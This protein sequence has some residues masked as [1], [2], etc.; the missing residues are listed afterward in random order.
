MKRE[1]LICT[2]ESL[3]HQA[4]FTYF[5]NDQGGDVYL[6]IHLKPRN[7][8][9]RIINAV[10]YVFGHRSVYGDFDEMVINPEDVDKLERIVEYLKK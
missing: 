1:T 3:E 9:R 10:R 4:V 2:C 8:F 6:E 7:L 5:E